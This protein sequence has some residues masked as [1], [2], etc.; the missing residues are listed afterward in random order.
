M[1]SETFAPKTKTLLVILYRS[2]TEINLVKNCK[3]IILALLRKMSSK[4][5]YHI[6]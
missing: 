1:Y 6:K 5:L 3:M 4:K 2:P